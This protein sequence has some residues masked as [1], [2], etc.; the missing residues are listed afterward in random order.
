M[1]PAKLSEQ[2]KKKEKSAHSLSINGTII[3]PFHILPS[4]T[5]DAS[6]SSF[7]SP[8]D[9]TRAAAGALISLSSLPPPPPRPLPPDHQISSDPEKVH[10][11]FVPVNSK[12]SPK[13][14]RRIR[15]VTCGYEFEN[16]GRVRPT[17]HLIGYPFKEG[18]VKRVQTCPTPYL[19]LKE[20]LQK[21][22]PPIPRPVPSLPPRFNPPYH[23]PHAPVALPASRPLV[24]SSSQAMKRK[25]ISQTHENAGEGKEVKEVE[26]KV[27]EEEEEK[28]AATSSPAIKRQRSSH[29]SPTTKTEETEAILRSLATRKLLA[30]MQRYHLPLQALDDN[31]F[32]EFLKILRVTNSDYLPN[33]ACLLNDMMTMWLSYTSINPLLTNNS[34]STSLLP[35]YPR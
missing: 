8:S 25:E 18:M 23:H 24:D 21:L 4:P 3:E 2:S 5:P 28:K 31:D 19:P 7:P 29:N 35:A 32:I 22:F 27:E 13:G 20:N 15:C 9:V 6:S 14:S 30:F 12:K 33:S 10:S 1:D 11:H 34:N 26:E 17:Q 16:S